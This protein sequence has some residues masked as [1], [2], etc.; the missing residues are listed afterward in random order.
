MLQRTV[1]FARSSVSHV[2]ARRQRAVRTHVTVFSRG[3]IKRGLVRP[4]KM[5]GVAPGTRA[6]SRVTARSQKLEQ[7]RVVHMFDVS[8]QGAASGRT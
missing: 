8:A 7:L 4:E 2:S 1:V 3:L 6:I 5:I